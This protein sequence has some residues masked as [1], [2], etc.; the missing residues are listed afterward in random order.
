M[1]NL[2]LAQEVF[3]MR[4][5]VL[6]T[7][8]VLLIAGNVFAITGLGF[9]VRAG[10]I[11]GL[12]TGAV[13]DAI[14]TFADASGFTA[15]MDDKMTMVGGHVKIG[16]LPMIDLEVA[17][18]YA[19]KKMDLY[20]GYQFKISDFSISATGIYNISF[21]PTP[22]ITPYIGAGLGTHKLA[23]SIEK[24]G[25]SGLIVPAD[26]TEMGYHGLLGAKIHPP[27]FPL[28]FFAQYRYTYISTEDVATKYS[29]ILVGATINLP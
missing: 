5:V 28:E 18:E 27:M 29:T 1:L 8:S 2:I 11:T 13:E 4:A 24:P 15:K 21:V 25:G 20:S 9:G 22:M 16:T 10:Y 17:A 6:A 7:L 3:E 26:A 23:Y 12:D 14:N 19:W